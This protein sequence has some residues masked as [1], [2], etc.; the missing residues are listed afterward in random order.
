M[1]N[2]L[3]SLTKLAV[4]VALM[5][6]L[7]QVAVTAQEATPR[8]GGN[9]IHIFPTLSEAAALPPP[10][11]P[12]TY[13]GGKVMQS[14]VSTYAI[15]WV[16]AKLQNGGATSMTAHYQLVQKNMLLDYAAHGIDNNNTQYY[17]VVGS[18]T[19]Y[20]QNK[21]GL[22]AF[23]VDTTAYPAS[24]CSDAATPGNCI[25]DAQIQAEITKVMG[26]K[27]WTGGLNK[28]FLLFT[29]SGEGSCS[30]SGS[31]SCAYV[32]YCAYHGFFGPAA[33]P[34]IYGNEPFG[35]LSVCQAP[36]T[37]SPN[38]DA[39][40]DA[41]ASTATHELTE[42]TTDPELN[43]WFDSSGAEIGD[44]CAYLYGANTWDSAKA[45]QMWNGHF[46]ELQTEY[47]NHLSGCVQVG[48]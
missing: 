23:Y 9:D 46:Y 26:I 35:D 39:L 18:A 11:T 42:A 10:A 13:H 25:T 7:L 6:L 19:Q 12:L 3:C 4:V 28:M 14:G 30:D 41:A 33:T 20:I 34:T 47:D 44:K 45:N 16:P 22:A 15:F 40:A 32:Q 27:A 2:Q 43:A 29:S 1:K 5:S 21:G 8:S 37:P 31:T 36:G 48:P 24:G 17:Q 38:G